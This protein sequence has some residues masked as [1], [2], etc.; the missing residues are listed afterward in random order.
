[1]EKLFPG[2]KILRLVVGDITRVPAD[3]IVNAANAALA[4]GGGVDGAIHR[5]GGPAIMEELDQIRA[6]IGRCATGDAV[7]TTAGALPARWVFHA[8]GPVYRDG[9]HGEAGM[10]AS[11]YATCLRMAEERD[12]RTISFPSISTG[13]YGYPLEAAAAIALD[14]VARHLERA[15][16]RVREVIFVLFD[17]R[18]YDAHAGLLEATSGDSLE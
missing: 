9:R 16:A 2:G 18:A 15:E 7:A 13:A 17:R 8:V 4:G 1:M 6:R 11:C 14:T 3:A 10:L 5:A 12:A